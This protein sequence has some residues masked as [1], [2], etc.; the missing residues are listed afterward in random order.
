M[1]A[2]LSL[3]SPIRP[4][5][6]CKQSRACLHE[7][8]RKVCRLVYRLHVRTGTIALGIKEVQ[9]RKAAHQSK[10]KGREG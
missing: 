3:V 8:G 6:R 5:G 4:K 2:D 10:C 9:T 7:E 1:Y